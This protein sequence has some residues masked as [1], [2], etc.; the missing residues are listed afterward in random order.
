MWILFVVDFMVDVVDEVFEWG[1][2]LFVIYY[3]LLL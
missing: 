3:L 2:Y 1:V